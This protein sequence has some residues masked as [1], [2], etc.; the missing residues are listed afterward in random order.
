MYVGI[1][2]GTV[3]MVGFDWRICGYGGNGVFRCFAAG[4]SWV[5]SLGELVKE[6]CKGGA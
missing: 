3:G 4:L 1:Y 5:W 6:E 2:V